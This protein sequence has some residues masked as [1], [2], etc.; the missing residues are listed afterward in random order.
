LNSRA[1]FIFLRF[2]RFFRYLLFAAAALLILFVIALLVF[3]FAL[4]PQ[5]EAQPRKVADFLGERIG[6][7][8]AIGSIKTGWDWWNPQL[9][10][11]DL[12]IYPAAESVE[13]SAAA[14]TNSE[15]TD[16]EAQLTLPEVELQIDAW[17]SL[18]HL[19]IRFHRLQIDRPTLIARHDT[20]GRLFIGGVLLV[21]S[22]RDEDSGGKFAEWF[23]R[24]RVIEINGGTVEWRD[25]KRDAPPLIVEQ[26]DFR[27][28]RSL[29]R[30]RFGLRGDLVSETGATF[31]ARGEAVTGLL[32]RSLD[33]DWQGYVRLERVD[34]GD[35]RQWFDLPIEVT[36]GEGNVQAWVSLSKQRVVSITLDMA[37]QNFK[38]SLAS[39]TTPLELQEIRGRFTGKE[40]R[41]RLIFSTEG[42]TFVEKNGERL[43]PMTATLTLE[44][45]SQETPLPMATLLT[46]APRGRVEFDRLDVSVLSSLLPSL[47]LPDSWREPLAAL[48]IRGTLENGGSNWERVREENSATDNRNSD[49]KKT[50]EKNSDNEKSNGSPWRLIHYS[51]RAT[52]RNASVQTY[53]S[54][55][56]VRGINGRVS[57][58]ETQGTMALDG[59]DVVFDLP[60]V[61]PEALPLGAVGGN[62]RWSRQPEG[63]SVQIDTL[64]FANADAEGTLTGTWRANGGGGVADLSAQL[65]RATATSAYRYI[66]KIAGEHIRHWLH[67]SIKSGAVNRATMVLKGDLSHFPFAGGKYG[68]FMI[69]ARAT[70]VQLVY[71]PAWPAVNDV[72]ADLRFE[73]ESMTITSRRGSI[74]DAPI[75]QTRAVILD[76]GAHPAHL[77]IEGS[78]N[79]PMMTYLHFLDESPI[80][81]WLDHMLTGAQA[82]GDSALTLKLDI[83][84]GG[85]EASAVNGSVK[86]AGNTLDLPGVPLLTQAHGTLSFTE[87]DVKAERLDFEAL[88]GSGTLA[89]TSRNGVVTLTGSGNADLSKLRAG[90]SLPLLDRLSGTTP[91]QLAFNTGGNK[92]THWVLTSPLTGVNVDLPEPLGKSANVAALLRI[93]HDTLAAAG[94]EANKEEFWRIDYRT[95][96]SPLTVLARRVSDN[97]APNKEV[98]RLERAL[99]RVGETRGGE[100]LSL[101]STPGLSVRGALLKLSTDRWYALYQALPNHE[102]VDASA[103]A[104]PLNDVDVS[105]GELTTLGRQLN[106]TRISA[107]RVADVWNIAFTGRE[108]EGHMTWE[109]AGANGAVN[110]RLKA[111]FT[112]LAFPEEA[113]LSDKEE[114]FVNT[115]LIPGSANPWPA[116]DFKIDRFSYK[117]KDFG[118]LTIQAEPRGT[119]WHMENTLANSGGS[120]IASGWWRTARQAQRTELNITTQ[121]NDAEKFLDHFG[122]PRSLVAADVHLEGALSWVGAPRDFDIGALDGHLNLTVGRGHFTRIEPGIGRLLGVFSLQA[123]PRR[124]TLDFRDVFSEGFAFDSITG[125]TEINK[126]ILHTDDLQM[127][128]A[129]A[130]VKL[131]GDVDLVK[132]AQNLNVHV[133]PSLTDSLSVGAAGASALLMTNPVSAAVVGLGALVGQMILGNPIEKIFSYEYTVKGSWDDPVVEKKSR[134]EVHEAAREEAPHENAPTSPS[135]EAPKSDEIKNT[136]EVTHE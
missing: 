53:G 108:G 106:D 25:E 49:N 110:G 113:V 77:Y 23:L 85:N 71:D 29:S 109:R 24:Q 1:I 120:V 122:V 20:E 55:P 65:Q 80:G 78:A 79:A 58:D 17:D 11:H 69:D 74:F 89:L 93:A 52:V 43:L 33:R 129:S 83:P 98:W 97:G 105:V 72:E 112:R 81:G 86:L 3:R 47:P 56:G 13:K 6:L 119:D 48:D 64:R 103:N 104:L 99:V 28:E 101:P 91:W 32:Q 131:S 88:G 128:G 44:G 115:V 70:G 2:W 107:R 116:I 37:L 5:W 92:G 117:D 31:E 121:I 59:R 4:L 40:E 34:L 36:R 15:A 135:D 60:Q 133:Q 130:K 125:N 95:A 19:D 102:S 100:N 94:K 96:S 82:T 67:E 57:F 127:N 21:A 54:Y 14:D 73:N 38:T 8:V 134:E 22:P 114:R 10:I 75:G 42:L 41:N 27:G 111:N 68:S 9:A 63:L 39:T 124:I 90:E 12:Q 66:P 7:P 126:G 26:L 62:A 46:Q 16:A 136:H 50:D 45:F 132:E 87:H 61:F 76:L 35:L 84:L 30:Y 51:A 18:F 123:L 118:Q